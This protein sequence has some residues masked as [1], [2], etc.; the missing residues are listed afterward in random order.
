LR[1]ALPKIH[2]KGAELIV[3]GNGSVDMANGFREDLAMDVPLYTDPT[4]RVYELAGMKYGARTTFNLKT[5]AH[6]VR[7][8]RAGF[9]Q[10]K[11]L[12]SPHQ[13]GGMLVIKPGGE[14]VYGY[15]SNEAGDQPPMHEVLTA[16]SAL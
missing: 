15:A 1:D 11:V 2:E 5:L 9:R 12:G 6:G 3:I 4:L 13:Q 14:I 7:A 16:V 10:T 8:F